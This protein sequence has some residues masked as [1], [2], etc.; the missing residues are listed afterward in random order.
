RGP[1][2]LPGGR[3]GAGLDAEAGRVPHEAQQARRS[4][5]RLHED[6]LPFS[7]NR[8][9]R[10]GPGPLDSA[11]VNTMRHALIALLCA[12]VAFAAP[13]KKAAPKK[14]DTEDQKDNEGGGDEGEGD[15]GEGGPPEGSMKAAPG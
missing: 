4:A 1:G 2:A 3:R 8:G 7:R 12:S 11:E 10:S 6:R 5:R 9:G 13:A 15:E 14:A